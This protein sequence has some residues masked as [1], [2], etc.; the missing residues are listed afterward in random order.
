[1]KPDR[2]NYEIW[3]IDL[4]DGNLDEGR[5]REL[6]E[7]L[8]ANPDLKEEFDTLTA[9]RLLPDKAQF[10]PKEKLFKSVSE[11]PLSQIE[12]LSVASLE[13]DITPEQMSEL[14]KNI[15]LDPENKRIF[16]SFQ[17]IRLIPPLIHYKNKNQ[18]KK[19]S[20]YGKI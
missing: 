6:M 8:D 12:Y 11:L 3:L 7:F 17:K 5:S 14:K 19:Y 15:S 2:T 1:M 18:L 9:L 20:Q 13:K 4:L 10:T 16:D